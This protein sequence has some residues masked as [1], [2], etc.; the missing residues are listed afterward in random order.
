MKKQ[1]IENNLNRIHEW[2]KSVDQKVSIFL[3]FQGI[4]LTLLFSEV[5][6]W[7]KKHIYNFSCMDVFIFIIGVVSIGFSLYKSIAVIIPRLKNHKKYKSIIYFKDIA[8]LDLKDYKKKVLELKEEDYQDDLINQIHISATIVN[9]K[10]REFRD[11]IIFFLIGIGLLVII[12][13]IQKIFY[14]N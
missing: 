14:G 12:F 9:R 4:T 2:I 13:L 8:E 7:S 6:F 11:S 10:N 1:E 5:F 3:A